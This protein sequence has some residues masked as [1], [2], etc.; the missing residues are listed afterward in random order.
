MHAEYGSL[1]ALHSQ[2]KPNHASFTQT[3]IPTNMHGT[4]SFTIDRTCDTASNFR[5]RVRFPALENPDLP[6]WPCDVLDTLFESFSLGCSQQEYPRIPLRINNTIARAVRLWPKGINS[7]LFGNRGEWE[8]TIPLM[9]SETLFPTECC[10]PIVSIIYDKMRVVLYGL[11]KDLPR[12]PDME[13]DYDATMMESSKRRMISDNNQ[14][15]SYPV[16]N[17]Q[18]ISSNRSQYMLDFSS[19]CRAIIIIIEPRLPRGAMFPIT[20]MQI[21]FNG[22]VF[23]RYVAADLLENNWRRAHLSP[24]KDDF[25]MLFPLVKGPLFSSCLPDGPNLS[26][27]V[28][29]IL[30]IHVDENLK[31]TLEN[32]SYQFTALSYNERMTKF[33]MLERLHFSI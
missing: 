18:C 33:G 6:D 30:D 20:Y 10:C 22:H 23:I 29:V 25:A 1:V 28:D 8:C 3:V 31:K 4:S 5:L 12:D 13:L 2:D 24:P 32:R 16:W 26:R 7:Q 9:F 15:I 19:A 14:F 27:V 11:R 17:T 21:S